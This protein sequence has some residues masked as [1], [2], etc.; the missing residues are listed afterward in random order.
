M[1]D[2]KQIELQCYVEHH[3]AIYSAVQAMHKGCDLAPYLAAVERTR[4]A[5]EAACGA[6]TEGVK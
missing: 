1:D 5:W 4:T 3:A 6:L 2:L